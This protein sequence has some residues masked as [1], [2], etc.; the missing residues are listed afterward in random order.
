MDAALTTISLGAAATGTT[1]SGATSAT[2]TGT[3]ASRGNITVDTGSSQAQPQKGKV[4]KGGKKG[5]GDTSRLVTLPE[6][7]ADKLA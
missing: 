4:K 6:S 2:P 7:A 1:G 3:S 5:G